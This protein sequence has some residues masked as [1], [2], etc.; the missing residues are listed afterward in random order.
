MS[1]KNKLTYSVVSEGGQKY[2]Q[3]NDFYKETKIWYLECDNITIRSHV[4]LDHCMRLWFQY[5]MP[6]VYTAG[7]LG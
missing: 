1:T 7:S 4:S 5:K 6:L 3:P 2:L